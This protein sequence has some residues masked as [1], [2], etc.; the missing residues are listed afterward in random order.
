[1]FLF[2]FFFS[3]FVNFCFSCSLIYRLLLSLFASSSF[4]LLVDF[5]VSFCFFFFLLSSLARFF[6]FCVC[7]CVC[8]EA[9][10]YLLC[11]YLGA[12]LRFFFFLVMLRITCS[13][14]HSRGMIFLTTS[15]RRKPLLTESV[16]TGSGA[17]KKKKE[18]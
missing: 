7:V 3:T 1:M 6:F 9:C 5:A 8:E 16:R 17:K 10:S 4:I 18:G 14:A 13:S 15:L 2:F 12:Y 11:I